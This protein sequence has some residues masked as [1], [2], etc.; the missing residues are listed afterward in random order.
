MHCF[1]AAACEGPR[2][3]IGAI[4]H[5]QVEPLVKFVVKWSVGIIDVA[6]TR[7]YVKHREMWVHACAKCPI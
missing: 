3:R 5:E 7:A 6:R 2:A 1:I 4:L